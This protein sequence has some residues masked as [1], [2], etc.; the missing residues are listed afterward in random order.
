LIIALDHFHLPKDILEVVF[1]MGDNDSNN[2]ISWT[3]EGDNYNWIDSENWDAK[4]TPNSDDKVT[5]SSNTDIV[6]ESVKVKE[7]TISSCYRL[8]GDNIVA[9]KITLSGRSFINASVTATK[10][11]IWLEGEIEKLTIP[12]D[13]KLILQGIADKT[14]YGEL[15]NEGTIIW[16]SFGRLYLISDEGLKNLALLSV[17]TPGDIIGSQI[18]NSGTI[19]LVTPGVSFAIL[20]NMKSTGTIDLGSGTLEMRQGNHEFDSITVKGSGT[21]RVVGTDSE[22]CRLSCKKTIT[23]GDSATFELG[24]NALI[25]NT[26]TF[27]GGRFLWL[28]GEIIGTITIGQSCTMSIE[29]I[30]DKVIR[31]FLVNENEIHCQSGGRVYIYNEGLENRG[32]L[33]VDKNA[34]FTGSSTFRNLGKIQFTQSDSNLKFDNVGF[35][36]HGEI[37]LGTSTLKVDGSDCDLQF[38]SLTR[39]KVENNEDGWNC[40][41]I[42]VNGR[43]TLDGTLNIEISGNKK[44]DSNDAFKIIQ[45]STRKNKFQMITSPDDKRYVSYYSDWALFWGM[46]LGVCKLAMNDFK[47]RETSGVWNLK[48]DLLA[49]RLLEIIEN[50]DIIRQGSLGLCGAA[51]FLRIWAQRDPWAVVCFSIELYEKGYATI[52]DNTIDRYE[53]R[54]CTDLL[55]TDYDKIEW[56][57]N[58]PSPSAEWMIMSALRDTENGFFDYGGTPDEQFS[59]ITMPGAVVKWLKATAIYRDVSDET[60]NIPINTGGIKYNVEHAKELKPSDSRDVIMF[61]NAWMINKE[62][63]KTIQGKLEKLATDMFPTHYI[64]LRTPVTTTPDGKVSFSYFSW[65]NI[66]QGEIDV[67]IFNK[68]YYGGIISD[69]KQY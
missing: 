22:I 29:G 21:L 58:I 67:D 18:L 54:P 13:A 61:I 53:V 66:F 8:A 15:V 10:E 44:L 62:L 19:A 3:G 56:P 57:S 1:I 69:I 16:Q 36:S 59:C 51:A 4:R 2:G 60:P 9:D 32:T 6:F 34:V 42:I 63:P 11:F 27:T 55:N 43:I 37:E 64:G 31:G 25:D 20:S 49:D 14:L 12:V 41:R 52:R 68:Y 65:G 50:P 23:I 24:N 39:L 45:Y 17:E 30:G 46:P 38:G 40:G 28:G 7:L 48:R 35:L 47:D 5:I 33:I 26:A